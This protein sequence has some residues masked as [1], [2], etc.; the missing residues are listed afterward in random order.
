MAQCSRVLTALGENLSSVPVTH[1]GQLRNTSDCSPG[2]FLLTSAP[3]HTH[4]TYT[5]KNSPNA[6]KETPGGSTDIHF[7]DWYFIDECVCAK[8]Y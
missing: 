8:S 5:D 6:Y 7:L 2:E 4:D 1:I 3:A